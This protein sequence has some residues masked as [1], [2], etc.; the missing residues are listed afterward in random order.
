M[1]L[2]EVRLRFL[3]LKRKFDNKQFKKVFVCDTNHN[4]IMAKMPDYDNYL[5]AK[6]KIERKSEDK[7]VL[8]DEPLLTK[9]QEYHLF[10]QYNY[11]K[12]RCNYIFDKYD[13][14]TIRSKVLRLLE[15][16]LAQIANLKKCIAGANAR[17]AFKLA[18]QKQYADFDLALSDAYFGL[19]YCIDHFD[20]TRNFRF[21]TYAYYAIV[22]FI[23]KGAHA[24]RVAKNVL[25]DSEIINMQ[26]ASYTD[27]DDDEATK[28]SRMLGSVTPR[29]RD[30]IKYYYG[31]G[32]R[33]MNLKE[34][35]DVL[36][37]SKERVRQIKKVGL[38]RMKRLE[39]KYEKSKRFHSGQNA[40]IPKLSNFES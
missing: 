21:L 16:Y 12:S 25:S 18:K 35:S 2:E 8:Y 3:N 24:D 34:I 26:P 23:R 13:L 39:L 28:I 30:I 22:D 5:L 32:V 31:I 6:S 38:L 11:L 15:Q 29:E 4:K 10:R 20:Y 36:Q 40:S 14:S 19:V 7:F 17:M 1:Q 33:E 37:I 27:E 9:A